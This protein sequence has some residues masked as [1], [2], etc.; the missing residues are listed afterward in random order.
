MSLATA[1]P[2]I[3][4]SRPP[5]ANDVGTLTT[6]A[7]AAGVSKKEYGNGVLRQTLITLSNTA[8]TVTDTGGANGGYGSLQLLDLPAGHVVGGTRADRD[9]HW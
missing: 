7:Q 2:S 9:L 3:A 1:T 6:A 5:V 8:I 4:S